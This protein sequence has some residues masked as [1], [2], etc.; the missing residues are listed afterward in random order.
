MNSFLFSTPTETLDYIG[1]HSDLSFVIFAGISLIQSLSTTVGDNVILCSTS[2]EFSPKGYKDNVITGFSYDSEIAEIV[3]IMYP[4]AKSLYK[5]K[6]S[7]EKVKNNP[8]AFT[9]LLCDG[10]DAMEEGLITTFYFADPNFKI[11]G[12]SAGDNLKFEKTLIYIGKKEVHSVAIFFDM[13]K[14]TQLIKENIYIPSGKKLLV[15]DADPIK[16]TVKTFNNNLAT[17]EY[18][19]ML[20]IKEADLPNHFK[21]NP[22]G[23]VSKGE[24]YIASPMKVNPDKSIT[25]YCQI[26]PNT[27][28]EVLQPANYNIVMKETLESA[29]FKPS[30]V[31]SINCILRSLMFLDRNLWGNV[32]SNLLSLCENQAGFVSYGEQFY[33]NHFNQTMVLLLVE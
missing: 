30:F 22:L 13:K 24:I 10:L 8:N 18:A 9:L 17:V 6:K 5:L 26:L 27:F 25:F 21:N 1:C 15:T 2:G 11:I 28:V 16:R 29:V 23:K 33:Q 32:S 7:Y 14:R 12:G 20:G 19:K 3:E 4:P 31:L